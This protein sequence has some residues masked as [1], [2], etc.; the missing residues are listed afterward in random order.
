[1]DV[2]MP[3]PP[4][5]LIVGVATC[6]SKNQRF[7]KKMQRK[8][9]KE[10]GVE[11]IPIKRLARR[12]VPRPAP[13]VANPRSATVAVDSAEEEEGG[14]EE[15]DVVL[16][17]QRAKRGAEAARDEDEDEGEDEDEEVAP[18]PRKRRL[19]KRVIPDSQEEEGG[20]DGDADAGFASW[21][22]EAR[23]NLPKASIEFLK[24]CRSKA[25][26]IGGEY[27]VREWRELLAYWRANMTLRSR[28]SSRSNNQ[29]L[30]IA[31]PTESQTEVV[32]KFCYTYRQIAQAD[33]I[34]TFRA[35]ARRCQM[36]ELDDYYR[37][38]ED[39]DT[40]VTLRRGQ[41][42]IAGRKR[43]LFDRL[44]PQFKGLPVISPKV[45]AAAAAGSPE[46]SR[47]AQIRWG[48][49]TTQLTSAKR[50]K[51]LTVEFGFGILGLIPEAK[52]GN[53]W[54]ETKLKNRTEFEAWLMAIRVFNP[55]C[56]KASEDFARRLDRGLQGL[57][58]PSP[59]RLEDITDQDLNNHTNPQ[60]LFLA[61]APRGEANPPPPPPND[62]VL[63]D[64]FQT[65]VQPFTFDAQESW[66]NQGIADMGSTAPILHMFPGPEE[67]EFGIDNLSQESWE[68]F[69]STI[70]YDLD[71][72]L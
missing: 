23:K 44:Y 35:I 40:G 50:W 61:E 1:M 63:R 39:L 41:R 47:E 56:K 64:Q 32:D 21:V 55:G 65:L 20:G 66:M 34:M 62:L 70:G 46:P 38:V 12:R 8:R 58:P 53:K 42:K 72:P 36:V 57:G 54:V 13:A 25:R 29:A 7:L 49:F 52:V 51:D 28:P 26:A 37:Q 3:A 71:F 15:G 22:V 11:P 9:D 59:L 24:E 45:A 19:R 17:L 4:Q 43:Y 67:V 14:R 31:H 18:P 27:A 60:V 2:S 48:N 6:T 5:D 16:L 69:D 10:A 33:T 30:V 68:S